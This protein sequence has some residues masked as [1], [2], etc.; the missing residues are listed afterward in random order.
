MVRVKAWCSF[1]VV[2]SV[3]NCVGNCVGF[4]APKFPYE[5]SMCISTAQA[6]T[7]RVLRRPIFRRSPFRCAPCSFFEL[8]SLF[9]AGMAP[10]GHV[11][12]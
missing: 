10:S 4:T 2:S 5:M 7:N 8:C 9:V 11:E 6:R 12:V 3:A 1:E